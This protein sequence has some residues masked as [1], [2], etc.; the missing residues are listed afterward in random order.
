MYDSSISGEGLLLVLRFLDTDS[1]ATEIDDPAKVR[2][3]KRRIDIE[4][5]DDRSGYCMSVL[6]SPRLTKN[7][8]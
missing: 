1:Q 5:Y 2:C 8:F 4:G 7:I 3:S 6:Y